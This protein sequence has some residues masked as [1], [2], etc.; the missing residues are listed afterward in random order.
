MLYEAKEYMRVAPHAIVFPG[1]AI[2]VTVLSFN[3]VGE[4]L[5]DTLDPRF[6][7]VMR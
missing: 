4:A 5:R 2:F 1:L 7:K 3:I 6:R